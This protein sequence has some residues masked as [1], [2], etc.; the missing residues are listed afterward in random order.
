L[1]EE[2]VL[3]EQ[4]LFEVRCNVMEDHQAQ[5]KVIHHQN[6]AKNIGIREVWTAS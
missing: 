2:G 1:G 6:D 5:V 3:F 4:R